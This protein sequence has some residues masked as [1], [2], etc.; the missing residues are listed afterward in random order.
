VVTAASQGES[1]RRILRSTS[2]VGGATIIGI[3]IGI[4]RTKLLAL[5]LGPAGIG[6]IGILTNIVSVAGTLAA[7]G[8]P[9]SGV[10]EIASAGPRQAAVVGTLWRL[11]LWGALAGGLALFALSE[12]LAR[13][14]ANDAALSSAVA[15]TG[16]AVALSVLA[17]TQIAVLQGR[18]QIGALAKV[19]I[20]GAL[21][22]LVAALPALWLDP[23][24]GVVIAV[25]GVPLGGFIAG[26]AFADGRPRV[27]P[28]AKEHVGPLLTLGAVLMVTTFVGSLTFLAL[29]MGVTDSGGAEE[30]GFYQ[31]A[32]SISGMNVALVLAAM[33]ADYFPRLSSLAKDDRAGTAALVNQQL[34]A[35]LL[36]GGPLLVG[37]MGAAGLAV[38]VLFSPSFKPAGEVLQWQIFGDLLKFPGWA[39]G[40]VLVARARR[41]L[42]LA[43]ELS[44]AVAAVA[45]TFLLLPVFGTTGAAMGYAGAYLTY[46]AIMALAVWRSEGVT[47]ALANWRLLGLV[48]AAMAAVKLLSDAEASWGLAGGVLLAALLAG[49]SAR[50][51]RRLLKR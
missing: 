6:L 9:F 5:A 25:I 35:A 3:L 45:L 12:P 2:L 43:V 26:L 37:L 49:A 28:A 13:W 19:R 15:W 50:E 18:Q 36:L 21:L 39:L 47:V 10:K 20:A 31:A 17:G 34:R 51:L 24:T 7:L 42:F 30:A 8:T 44:F 11:A 48:L 4:A 23:L 32:F 27:A 33:S 46:S 41:F 29:R 38:V 40:Y 16:L 1:Y 14:S 22:G